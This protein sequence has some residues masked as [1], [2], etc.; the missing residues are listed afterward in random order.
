MYKFLS[1]ITFKQSLQPPT[2]LTGE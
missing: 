2:E 1:S